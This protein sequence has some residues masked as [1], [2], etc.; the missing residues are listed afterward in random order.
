LY[1]RNKLSISQ[2]GLS[3][4]STQG[5]AVR[6]YGEEWIREHSKQCLWQHR[7]WHLIHP[8]RE[9]RFKVRAPIVAEAKIA[10]HKF[11]KK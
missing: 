8:S 2:T 6:D 1:A 10:L 9:T 7:Y 11:S 5:N 4:P 3:A